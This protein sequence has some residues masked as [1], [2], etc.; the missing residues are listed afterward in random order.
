MG[1]A[2][3]YLLGISRAQFETGR[4]RDSAFRA[5]R[6]IQGLASG[7]TAGGCH[8]VRIVSFN[9]AQGWSRDVT[10]DIADDLR[11]R[12]AAGAVLEFLETIG[13]R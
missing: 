7:T 4:R 8:P 1:L 3:A 6:R 11:G 13:R 9:T 2:G 10:V 5:R 12:F